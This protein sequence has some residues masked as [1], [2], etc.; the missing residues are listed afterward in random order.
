[1]KQGGRTG[2]IIGG[3]EGA[4]LAATTTEIVLIVTFVGIFALAWVVAIVFAVVDAMPPARKIGW[5]AALVLLAP[6]SVPYFLVTRFRRLR[7][8]A[9][10]GPGAG[11]AVGT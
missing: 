1:M 8:E 7:R 10:E 5:I 3:V 2:A 4:L 11:S 9:R 6:V